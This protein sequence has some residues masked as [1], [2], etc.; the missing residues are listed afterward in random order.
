[1]CKDQ[2]SLEEFLTRIMKREMTGIRHRD[3]I[4]PL[5]ALVALLGDQ[6]VADPDSRVTEWV[7]SEGLPM[8]S[9]G[10]VPGVF[11]EDRSHEIYTFWPVLPSGVVGV[12][13]KSDNKAVT[14]VAD[15][16]WILPQE[17]RNKSEE[18][19]FSA[20]IL[21][22]GN[23]LAPVFND[24]IFDVLSFT[25]YDALRALEQFEPEI[26]FFRN[27]YPPTSTIAA[28]ETEAVTRLEAI[29]VDRCHREGKSFL[30]RL[31]ETAISSDGNS[32]G[33]PFIFPMFQLGDDGL[34]VIDTDKGRHRQSKLGFFNCRKSPGSPQ[35]SV[36]LLLSENWQRSILQSLKFG[37]AFDLSF[38]DVESTTGLRPGICVIHRLN[39]VPFEVRQISRKESAAFTTSAE[40]LAECITKGSPN[41]RACSEKRNSTV[42]NN[43]KLLRQ[44]IHFL[45]SLTPDQRKGLRR[46]GEG[47]FNKAKLA[48]QFL[49][50]RTAAG[51]KTTGNEIGSEPALRKF[52]IS[53]ATT[54]AMLSN[55]VWQDK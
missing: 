2:R 22:D 5:S 7:Q 47:A 41:D 40:Q 50:A 15:F 28:A 54:E 30:I 35:G 51:S 48:R 16:K 33:D 55:I 8:Y 37:Q 14:I 36:D 45:E 38:L 3:A 12:D 4:F 46:R 18:F 13:W 43:S 23:E 19:C 11:G 44:L 17:M 27:Y 52:M 1:V 9:F 39:L 29:D 34:K 21:R 25:A 24:S 10:R 20:R 26:K 53:D 32:E 49:A 6:D 31:P 42:E